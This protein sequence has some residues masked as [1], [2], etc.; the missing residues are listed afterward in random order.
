MTGALGLVALVTLA[1]P[2]E[3]AAY[4]SA[5]EAMVIGAP[6]IA[7]LGLLVATAVS[8]AFRR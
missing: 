5:H 2:H 6:A 7:L 1:R 3:V 4:A 8:V